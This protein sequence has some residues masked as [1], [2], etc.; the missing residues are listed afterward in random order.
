MPTITAQGSSSPK[1][2][3][4]LAQGIAVRPELP[5]HRLVDDHRLGAALLVLIGDGPAL[6]DGDA[7]GFEVAGAHRVH[8]DQ[9]AVVLVAALEEDG[10]ADAEGREGR[11]EAVAAE[12]TPGV[13]SEPLFETGAG[14][15]R[16]SRG[17]NPGARGRSSRSGASA[18]RSPG[19]CC[20]VAA[21][22]RR[23][24]PAPTRATSDRAT[25]PTTRRSRMPEAVARGAARPVGVL[26]GL[27]HVG[28]A[29]LER[30]Q[31]DR[32]ARRRPHPPP[33]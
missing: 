4:P 3:E 29:G 24:R 5:G 22:L 12:T 23:K 26:Q 18:F 33:G 28:L 15:P 10:A 9:G 1:K 16:P 14:R 13:P 2:L 32:R 19:P 30:G 21:R 20:A 17:C 27:D 6:H 11:A 7:H 8:V 31:R 25:W